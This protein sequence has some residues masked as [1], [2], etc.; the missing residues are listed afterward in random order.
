M[1]EN[2][3]KLNGSEIHIIHITQKSPEKEHVL[4][5]QKL[6]IQWA[7]TKQTVFDYTAFFSIFSYI[8]TTP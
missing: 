2:C 3:F 5:F 6:D 8:D 1:K 4:Q 7:F